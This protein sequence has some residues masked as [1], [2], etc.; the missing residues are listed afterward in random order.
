[1]LKGLLA[2]GTDDPVS[3]VNA[4][5]LAAERGL[6]VKETK[7]SAAHD[8]VNLITLRGG[9]HALAGSLFGLRAEARLVMVDEHTLDIPPARHMLIVRNEDRPGLIGLVGVTVG[10]AGVN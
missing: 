5:Q 10:Q 8:Y 9:D 6:E 1:M 7:T 4:P 3:Y 2:S